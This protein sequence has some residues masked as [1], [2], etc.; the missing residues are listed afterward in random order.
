MASLLTDLRF[1]SDAI[2]AAPGPLVAVRRDPNGRPLA[3]VAAHLIHAPIESVWDV[4]SDVKSYPGRVPM[5]E[6]VELSG[7]RVVVKLRFGM[8][9]FSVGF[10]FTAAVSKVANKTIE[11]THLAGEPDRLVLRYDLEPIEPGMTQVH[12]GITFEPDSLGWL[13]KYFLRHHPEIRYGIFPGCAVALVE[14][15]RAVVEGRR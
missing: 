12:A 14:S 6:K 10:S 11:L 13:A 3:A 2:R 5:L 8:S 4:V 9:L 1:P 7:D 15:M